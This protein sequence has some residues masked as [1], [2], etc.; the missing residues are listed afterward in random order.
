MPTNEAE[1]GLLGQ[2]RREV[3]ND[4]FPL[5]P[6]LRK[7]IVLGGLARSTEL[8][9]WASREANGYSPDD[10]LPNYRV[11]HSSLWIKSSTGSDAERV[12]QIYSKDS[13]L[14]QVNPLTFSED[15]EL[16]HGIGAIEEV[17]HRHS[18]DED[19]DEAVSFVIYDR[20][21]MSSIL[22]YTGDG[23]HDAELAYRKVNKHQLYVMLGQIRTILAGLVG[24]LLAIVPN[25]DSI[26]TAQ[27][28]AQAINVVLRGG[29]RHQIN[30][31][32]ARVGAKGTAE[33]KLAEKQGESRWTKAQTIW[34]IIGGVVAIIAAYIAYRQWRG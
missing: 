19:D 18:D 10:S 25:E 12:P 22:L 26:P 30:V 7:C 33:I 5:V 9:N 31:T 32:A 14:G 8:R 23:Y 15:F 16:R 1:P 28:A 24:E 13:T 34:T 17:L 29:N 6:L 3:V 11:I 4:G 27:Q 21:G 2:I 20:R